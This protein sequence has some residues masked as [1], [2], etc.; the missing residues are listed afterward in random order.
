[1]TEQELKQKIK[2]YRQYLEEGNKAPSGTDM[3]VEM[4]EKV[5]LELLDLQN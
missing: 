5:E 1:M 2:I 4:I 3:Y